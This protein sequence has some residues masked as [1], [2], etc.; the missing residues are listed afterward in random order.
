MIPD[1]GGKACLCGIDAVF[2]GCPLSRLATI[3]RS[4][5]FFPFALLDFLLMICTAS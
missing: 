3:W 1:L 5:R 4:P 2:K